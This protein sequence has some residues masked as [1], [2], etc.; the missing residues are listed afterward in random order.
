MPRLS[1]PLPAPIL[2]QTLLTVQVGDLNYGGHLSN[3]AVLRMVHEG[4]IRW[5]S[6]L[7]LS[8]L[9]IGGGGLIMLDA[10]V[11]YHAQAFHGEEILLTTGADDIG[12][13][14]F[15]FTAGL[16]RTADKQTIATARCHMA[17]FN[18]PRQQ[19]VRLPQGFIKHLQTS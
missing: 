16:Q 1:I 10:A 7:A 13:G 14:S 6:S 3:D 9:D 5:L 15:C 17:C 18:Y 2:F 4:R 11:Q 8:E 12:T 19:A